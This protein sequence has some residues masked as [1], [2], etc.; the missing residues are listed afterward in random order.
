M[1]KVGLVQI[2]NSF[3]NQNYLPLSV[4]LLQAYAQQ[5]LERPQDFEFLLPIYQRMPVREAAALLAPADVVFF[6]AYVWNIR[7]S[8]E[9]ARVVKRQNPD[10]LIVFGGPQV[11]DRAGDFLPHFEFIDLL[12]HGEGEQAATQILERVHTREWQDVPSVSFLRREGTLVT[13][14]KVQR[15]KDPSLIPSPYLTNV[16][17][18][19]MRAH[20]EE[21]WIVL[22]ETNRGCPFSCTF[23]DWGSAIQAKVTAFD[24]QRLL[25]EVDWFAERHIE[26]VFCAD[27]N[28]GI[29]PR[30]L[31]IAQYVADKKQA[32][33]YPHALSVQNTKNATERAY[34][35]QKILSDAGLSKGVA[36]A[37]Q[38][39]DPDTL[40][41]IK[42]E[43]ISVE[44]YQ[45]LQRRFTRDSVETYT[46]LILGLPGETYDSFLNAVSAIIENGQ[47]NRIQFNNLSILPNAEVGDPEYIRRYG[48]E[49][50]ECKII[51]VH[52]ANTTEEIYEHQVL[53][54]ASNTMP[55]P[56]WVRVRAFSWMT[57]L[58]HFDKIFQIPLVVL[59]S[60]SSLSYRN[61]IEIFFSDEARSYPTINAVTSFFTD[62]AK[63]IQDGGPE[64]CLSDQWLPI[65][66]PADEYVFIKLVKEARLDDFYSEAQALMTDLMAKEGISLPAGLLDESIT[67]NRSLI[68]RP[69]QNGDL[70]LQLSYNLWD[71][72]R[73][74]LRGDS[75]ALQ[76]REVQYTIE[77]T[78]ETWPSWDDWCLKV[79]WY[80]HRRGAYFYGARSLESELSGHH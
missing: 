30:D 43:N 15:L 13:T 45:E 62:K 52:G 2:N 22:W 78:V 6:S 76:E 53:V 35:V 55:R 48:L 24:I 3:S 51:N 74:I 70:N 46:D 71:Y 21:K 80:G 77:R 49:T 41:S 29:L 25:A 65:W 67:L 47:H 42:R 58:L 57:A 68:K 79:V 37:L 33:G 60:L 72:Y 31:E 64:Y 69:F 50:V 27:A 63:D 73:A 56:D 38:S 19:L 26:F 59:H 23:C 10:C 14:P 36:V 18:P 8:L 61:L 17:E 1:T 20:P 54:V 44:S 32:S 11:P 5:T 12:C 40:K 16:F 66:W 75:V 7:L 28:F 39:M 34:K 9:I 4:G